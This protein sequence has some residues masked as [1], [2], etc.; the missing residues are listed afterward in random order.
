MKTK[1]IQRNV[2][3]SIGSIHFMLHLCDSTIADLQNLIDSYI[4]SGDA[5]GAQFI[6]GQLEL[7]EP[8]FW[9]F[10]DVLEEQKNAIR[11][12]S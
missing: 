4:A 9:F 12:D 10:Y 8:W 3:M 1:F 11:R 5:E 2:T 7:I 6:S